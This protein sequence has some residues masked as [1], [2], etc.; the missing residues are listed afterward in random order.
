M[1]YCGVP[2]VQSTRRHNSYYLS[3]SVQTG[4][5]APPTHMQKVVGVEWCAMTFHGDSTNCCLERYKKLL[6]ISTYTTMGNRQTHQPSLE[7]YDIIILSREK[8][9]SISDCRTYTFS[10]KIVSAGVTNDI[11]NASIPVVTMAFAHLF[12]SLSSL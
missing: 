11:N 4:R 8:M 10:F 9:I 12:C 5:A 7:P 2:A 1:L 6:F 3:S